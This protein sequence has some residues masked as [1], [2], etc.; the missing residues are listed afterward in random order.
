MNVSSE[1]NGD[2]VTRLIVLATSLVRTTDGSHPIG[3]QR[4][5]VN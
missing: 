2:Q 3:V 1:K 4:S 5:T